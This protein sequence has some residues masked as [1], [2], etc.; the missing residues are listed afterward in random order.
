MIKMAYYM[1]QFSYTPSA[2]EALAKDPED[3]SEAVRSLLEEFDARLECFFYSFGEYDGVLI[4]EA[5]DKETVMAALVTA[6]A[7][8]HVKTNTTELFTVQEAM[9]AMRRASRHTYR[10]PGEEETRPSDP[11]DR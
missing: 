6:I 7:P 8:G 1:T 10:P 2:W 9:E 3:R 11:E 5:P 4:M